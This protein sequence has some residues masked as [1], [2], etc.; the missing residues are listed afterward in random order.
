MFSLSEK[1]DLEKPYEI[2]FQDDWYLNIGNIQTPYLK[3]GD[4][5]Y[6]IKGEWLIYSGLLKKI[7]Q[8]HKSSPSSEPFH[9]ALT[10]STHRAI[11]ASS[12][13]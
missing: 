10:S 13:F 1:I 2:L 8:L 4:N 3:Q 5:Y 12:I 9:F 7:F 11:G 6:N